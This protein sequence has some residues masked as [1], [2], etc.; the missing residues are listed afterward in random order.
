LLREYA[1]RIGLGPQFTIHDREDSADLMNWARHEAGLSETRE[2]FPTKATCLA[3]YSRVVNAR[4]DL[5]STLGKW[6]PFAAA[7]EAAL[8]A[9][10]AAYVEAKQRQNVLVGA[11]LSAVSLASL[12]GVEGLNVEHQIDFA[13]AFQCVA[14]EVDELPRAE[15][16][17]LLTVGRAS[18]ADDVGAGLTGELRHHRPDCA[19]RAVRD[20]ATPRPKAAVLEKSLPRGEARD[21]QARAHCEVNITRQRLEVACLDRQILCQGAVAMPVGDAEHSLSYHSPVVP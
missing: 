18:G 4:G 21:W 6:F 15:V 10:F 8:R 1:E 11:R 12:A 17:R 2:R 16:E 13:D 3:I 14:V 5:A 9:L 20:Y 7:H 19:G